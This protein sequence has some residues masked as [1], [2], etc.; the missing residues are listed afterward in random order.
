VLR[1]FSVVGVGVEF[2]LLEYAH[3]LNL[4]RADVLYLVFGQF[5]EFI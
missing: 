2:E 4:G 5:V 1:E 3:H